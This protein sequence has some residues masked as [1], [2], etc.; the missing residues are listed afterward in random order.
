MNVRYSFVVL[1]SVAVVSLGFMIGC[2]SQD[3][4]GDD[5][6]AAPADGD[7]SAEGDDVVDA[8]FEEVDDDDKKSTS[9]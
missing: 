5:P 2:G 9:A 3:Q 6:D 1:L 8:D 4:A 7:P